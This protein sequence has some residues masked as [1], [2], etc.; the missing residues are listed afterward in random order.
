MS[1]SDVVSAYEAEG[2]SRTDA[3]SMMRVLRYPT[4]GGLPVL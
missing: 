1:D 2:M 3:E 4:F